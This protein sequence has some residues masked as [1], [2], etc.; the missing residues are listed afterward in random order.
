MIPLEK[1]MESY[2]SPN[3]LYQRQQDFQQLNLGLYFVKNQ[4][5]G[6][7]WYR[8]QDAFIV[9]IGIQ[10]KNFKVVCDCNTVF[11]V[12]RISAFKIK[13]EPDK[14]LE[15]KPFEIDTSIPK[16]IQV[17]LE[18][19]NKACKLFISYGFTKKK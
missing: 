7:V 16:K 14:I 5:V 4:I 3:I 8:N 13:Y 6:G 9:L 2:I 15:N 18:L 19:L 1:G 11:K 10:T 12:K 17:P